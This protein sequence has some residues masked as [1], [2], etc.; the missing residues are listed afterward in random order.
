MAGMNSRT[1]RRDSSVVGAFVENV[2]GRTAEDELPD[3]PRAGELAHEGEGEV[4]E[5]RAGV[6][7]GSERDE[8]RDFVAKVGTHAARQGEVH[9][10]GENVRRRERASRRCD[11]LVPQP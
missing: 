9:C 5:A 7:G 6:D 3:L 4:A 1:V 8:A 10:T 11:L 2:R